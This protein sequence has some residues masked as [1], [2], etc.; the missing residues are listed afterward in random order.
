MTAPK[1]QNSQIMQ[2]N[3]D[4]IMK[5]AFICAICGSD[6]LSLVVWLSNDGLFCRLSQL[7]LHRR[8]GGKL[9]SQP[10]KNARRDRHEHHEDHDLSDVVLD[11]EVRAIEKPWHGRL[12][13]AGQEIAEQ[14]HAQP[15]AG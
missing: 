4:L 9:G 8:L 13:G 12:D 2:I 14:E 10:G 7:A 11:E 1:S 15:P 6:L 3:A 5:S